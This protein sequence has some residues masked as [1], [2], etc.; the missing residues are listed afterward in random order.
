MKE[1]EKARG[2]SLRS[3]EWVKEEGLWRFC[4]RIYVPMVPELRQRIAEQHHDSKIGRHAGRW[5]TLELIARSYWWP[6]MS[7]YIGQYCKAC[8]TC[9]RTKAQK[10]KPFSELHPL[11]I[12]KARWDIVSVD[13]ITKL[14]DSHGF[15]TTM[16]VVDSVSK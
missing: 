5:K 8:D 14:P 12:P 11:P 16:V 4:D 1:L 10:H 15:N 9:L 7:R 13:F 3:S 2:K 6:N